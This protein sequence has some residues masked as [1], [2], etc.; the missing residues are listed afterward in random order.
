MRNRETGGLLLYV[1]A[2]L[3]FGLLLCLYFPVSWIYE[4]LTGVK[5]RYARFLDTFDGWVL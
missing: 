3:G 1:L 5:D 4:V 2:I